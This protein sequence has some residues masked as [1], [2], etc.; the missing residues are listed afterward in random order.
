MT[1][2]LLFLIPLFAIAHGVPRKTDTQDT[3]I[4]GGRFAQP[5]EV[6][7]QVSLQDIKTEEHFCG[8]VIVDQYYILTAAHCVDGADVSTISANVGLINLQ[9]PHAVH[10][11]ESSYIH[12]DYNP[13]DSWI[14]DIALLK[15]QSPIKFSPLV[16]AV[17]LTN[18]NFTAGTKAVVSGF[19]RLSFEGKKATRLYV[20]DIEIADQ[21]YC[22]NVYASKFKN[23]YDT[24]LCANEPTVEKGSCQGDSGGPLTVNG[25]LIGLVSWSHRCSDTIYPTVYT[26][27]S[28]YFFWIVKQIIKSPSS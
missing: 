1:I 10:L 25:M 17:T 18:Q 6:P 20:A 22:R 12:E 24:Q 26:R 28:S 5:G 7:Y 16:D 8:G 2:Q 11:I 19:G 21:A 27:I 13:D 23:I 14:N 3:Q 15:L 4:V 9:E